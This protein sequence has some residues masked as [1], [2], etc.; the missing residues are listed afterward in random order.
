MEESESPTEH[1]QEEIQHAATHGGGHNESAES[2]AK[3][4]STSALLSAI[5]AVLAAISSLMSG[6]YANEAM[7]EQ[8]KS[9][10]QWAH[11]QAK[12]IKASIAELKENLGHDTKSKEDYRRDQEAI[13]EK[14]EEAQR[15]SEHN[16]RQH[17]SWAGAVT[18][19]QV[20]IAL[21]AITIL[22]RRRRFF[23][24]AISLSV[25]GLVMMVRSYFL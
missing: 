17:E 21:I 1:L 13:R 20:S 9:S 2:R 15:A 3:L 6:R 24:L 16:L 11:Y 12:S 8:I 23:A 10:D 22:T 18:F 14:A 7:I 4:I 25:V 19:F 5:V